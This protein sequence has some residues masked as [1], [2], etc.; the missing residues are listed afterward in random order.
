MAFAVAYTTQNEWE[1]KANELHIAEYLGD[2]SMAAESPEWVCTVGPNCITLTE[3]QYLT[4]VAS[5]I[6]LSFVC[7]NGECL[8][9]GQNHEWCNKNGQ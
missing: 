7:R 3:A 5:G 4:T 8:W 2:V 6:T 9:F 1:R